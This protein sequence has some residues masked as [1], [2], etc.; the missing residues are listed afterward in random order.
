[1]HSVL[2]VIVK[3]ANTNE[4]S[5][6][7][8]GR[9]GDLQL[10]SHGDQPTPKARDVPLD[11][12]RKTMAQRL[13]RSHFS[14]VHVT[15]TMEA[16]VTDMARLIRALRDQTGKRLTYTHLL[17]KPIAATL[18][19]WPTLNASFESGRL[20]AFE[21]VNVGVAVSLEDGLIVPVVHNADKKTQAEVESEL[22]I[23]VSRAREGKLSLAD[24]AG[25]TFTVTN[26]GMFEVDLF[27]PIINPPQVAIL[28]VGRAG[29][30]P[31]VLDGR[32]CA[33]ITLP[34]CLSFDHRVIDGATAAR[35]L[36]ALVLRLERPS[37]RT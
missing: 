10:M 23:L 6:K 15:I 9:P 28:G 29:D 32:I 5:Y 7:A 26:L 16:D 1:M 30:R 20:I 33:R 8:V 4:Y 13:W 34:L 14:A 24:V 17:I 36:K 25:G 2:Q 22:D 11:N 27:T 35:F 3:S 18:K 31:F 19:E 37:Q 12:R 21:Q